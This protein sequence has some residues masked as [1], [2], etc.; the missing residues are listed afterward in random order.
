M[1]PNIPFLKFSSFPQQPINFIK[2][3]S[4]WIKAAA[5]PFQ[6]IFVLWIFR[7]LNYFQKIIITTDSTAV[8][9]RTGT[10]AFNAYRVLSIWFQRQTLFNQDFVAPV[11]PKIVY[12]GE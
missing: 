9:R 10:F 4:F 6:H 5:S 1:I 7:I 3:K 8:L 11:I 12:V 2:I